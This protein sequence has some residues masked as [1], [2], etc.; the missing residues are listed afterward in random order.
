MLL[1][2]IPEGV[3]WSIFLLPVASMLVIAFVTRH[4][5]RLSGY[6]TIAAVGT[7]FLF[8][9]WALDSVIDSDGQALA[10]G[11]HH[12]LVI[13]TQNDVLLRLGGPNLDVSLGLRIDGL[14]AM[15]LVIV[16][17]VSLLVRIYS[18]GCVRGVGGYSMC[19]VYIAP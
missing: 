12:W 5:P 9:L 7:A 17:S 3:A 10:F 6:V 2:T 15:M 1:P 11:S 8:A 14:S 19:F 4:A 16:T 18:Q 13:S